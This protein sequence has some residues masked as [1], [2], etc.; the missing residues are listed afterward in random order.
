MLHDIRRSL[1]KAKEALNKISSNKYHDTLKVSTLLDTLN[2][3]YE[4]LDKIL[5]QKAGA[6]S[7]ANKYGHVTR[8]IE[9]IENEVDMLISAVSN[10]TTIP[11]DLDKYEERR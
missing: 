9:Q 4:Q 2:T 11:N 8:D 10:S 3:R 7:F 6:T 5:E 1:G